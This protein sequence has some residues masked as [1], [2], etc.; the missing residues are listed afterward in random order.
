MDNVKPGTEVSYHAK[1]RGSVIARRFIRHRLALVGMITF[2][3]IYL[4]GLIGE[5]VWHYSY[6]T[7]TNAPPQGPSLQH[8]FG[9][10][11]IGHDLFAQVL[12]GTVTSMQ[13][14]LLV[15]I[16]STGFG[17]L[18]G[19]AAGYF[20]RL[21]DASLMRFT[22]LI[23]TLPTLAVLLV[24]GNVVRNSA[25]SAFW[26]GF[27][28]ASLA[29]TYP[30]RI[31]RGTFLSLRNQE[32]VEASRALGSGSW[33]TIVRHLLPNA[34]GPI[35]VTG[36]LIVAGAVL[37]EAALSF[38]G[39]GIQPPNVSLGLLIANNQEDV[40]NFPWLFAFPAGFL[41]LIV[42]CVNFIGDG[43]RDAF[44]PSRTRVRA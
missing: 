13:V 32:F 40:I 8:P 22:D 17:T 44:D 18:V 16:A 24:L 39:L 11:L 1:S 20:G 28:I 29:W 43:L 25:G 36:T 5:H 30:A 41:I 9:T 6:A 4:L 2:V 27:I 33:R 15:A 34:I 23:L 10:D 35:I 14:A 26:I 19:A 31:V 7:L 12:H 42:L 37:I 3:G 21:V 38:L